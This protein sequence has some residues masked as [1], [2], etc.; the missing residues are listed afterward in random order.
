MISSGIERASPRCKARIAGV[1][2]LT[3]IVV[4]IFGE[5]FVRGRLGFAVGLIAVSCNIAVTLVLYDIFKPVNRSLSLLAASS[6]FVGLTFEALRWNPRG[7]DI[8]IV[9]HGFYCLLIGYLILRSTFLPRILGALMAFAGLAWLTFLSPPLANYLYPYIL[10][11]GLLGEGSLMLWLLVIGV[12]VQRWKEQASAA[13]GPSAHE[14]RRLWSS[15]GLV[16]CH[17][18]EGRKGY[19]HESSCLLQVRFTRRSQ[20]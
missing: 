6:N 8:A 14:S 3:A 19:R 15:G 1:L 4:G 18:K 2:Y 16:S 17:A 7:V 10:A 11:S 12:N 5:F 9:F 20:M 13:G